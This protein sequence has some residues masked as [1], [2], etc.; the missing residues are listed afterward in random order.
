MPTNT[1]DPKELLAARK[2]MFAQSPKNRARMK[3]LT[4]LRGALLP[5]SSAFEQ[6]VRARPLPSAE[7]AVAQAE[8][9]REVH[10]GLGQAL[11]VAMKVPKL[12]VCA[13]STRLQHPQSTDT[14]CCSLH[15]S[16]TL[17]FQLWQFI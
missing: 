14:S 12:I 1:F 3:L 2:Q 5:F 17:P 15:T 4:E 16:Y 11:Q 7:G 13:Q 6:Q 8:R 9:A 10:E